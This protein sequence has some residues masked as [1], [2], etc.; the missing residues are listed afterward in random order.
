[1]SA[2]ARLLDC[3]V[4]LEIGGRQCGTISSITTAINEATE[5]KWSSFHKPDSDAVRTLN[6]AINFKELLKATSE[7]PCQK[8][9]SRHT[10]SLVAVDT[11]DTPGNLFA[12]GP[13]GNVYPLSGKTDIISALCPMFLEIKHS[14]TGHGAMMIGSDYQV[15]QQAAERILVVGSTNAS[16][17]ESIVIACTARSAW[18]FTFQR[19][20]MCQRGRGYETLIV[21]RI[22]HKDVFRVWSSYTIRSLENP[23][24]F[25]TDDGYQ[26]LEGIRRFANPYL[27]ISKL[28][29][30]SNHRVYGVSLPRVYS[31]QYS[32]G[33]KETVTEAV[34]STYD[35]CIK[36]VTDDE[37][38]MRE[39]TITQAVARQFE[40]NQRQHYLIACIPTS[41]A[42]DDTL[43]RGAD[44][45]QLGQMVADDPDRFVEGKDF[46]FGLERTA[47][48][49]DSHQFD[50]NPK[51]DRINRY[52]H[53]CFWLDA[54]CI[55]DCNK[56]GGLIVMKYGRIVPR[57]VDKRVWVANLF[58]ELELIHQSGF[59]HCD[60][61]PCN[62]LQF[63]ERYCLIDFDRAV[64]QN[65]PT[66]TF[67][68]GGLYDSRPASLQSCRVGDTVYWSQWLD[69]EMVLNTVI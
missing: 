22:R 6:K 10:K 19:N 7:K 9:L 61:R 28:I 36:I 47:A 15:L 32:N 40:A 34:A 45:M 56:P 25:L 52:T 8:I 5:I 55:P 23:Y 42:L 35:F 26:L 57:Y 59:F 4:E 14:G 38:Y 12:V 49:L 21:S 27:C 60:V 41:D 20:V 46:P 54:A 43:A 53:P 24:W 13:N 29:S 68:K 66:V 1:V 64:H 31:G 44:E 33:I 69:Y 16:I 39:A 3:S 67:V 50:I 11:S 65:D 62:V 51:L 48:V 30:S 18:I 58:D 2:F 63:G 17:A 37:S